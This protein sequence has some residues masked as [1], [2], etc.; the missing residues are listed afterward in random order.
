[1][2]SMNLKGKIIWKNCRFQTQNDTGCNVREINL[3]AAYGI[4]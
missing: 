2:G 1:M 3:A 4:N